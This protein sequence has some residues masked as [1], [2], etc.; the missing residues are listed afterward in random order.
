MSKFKES[1]QKDPIFQSLTVEEKDN[2]ILKSKNGEVFG[3]D[4]TIGDI[5]NSYKSKEDGY[6][7]LVYSFESLG[8]KN[9]KDNWDVI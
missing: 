6:L 5:Y 4:K 9:I 7:Y 3:L 8:E 2:F 1:L